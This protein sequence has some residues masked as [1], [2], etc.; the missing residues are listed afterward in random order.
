MSIEEY[1]PSEIEIH[2]L[3][4]GVINSEYLDL[5]TREYLV[6]GDISGTNELS[7]V[8]ILLFSTRWVM[9]GVKEPAVRV[10]ARDSSS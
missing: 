7:S 6:V 4:I 5:T 2:S 8:E 10:S 9:R 3:G 1:S